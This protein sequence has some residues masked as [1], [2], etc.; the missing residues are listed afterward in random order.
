MNH[1]DTVPSPDDAQEPVPPIAED[2]TEHGWVQPEATV[3][4]LDNL[5]RADDDDD[6]AG[7]APVSKSEASSGPPPMPLGV[8]IGGGILILLLL[9]G[10]SWLG[11]N[12]GGS[13]EPTPTPTPTE[14]IRDWPLDPPLVHEDWVRG[15]TA[16]T[17]PV[18]GMERTVVA[19]TYS[20]G[21]ERFALVLSRPEL[22][23]PEYLEDAAIGSIEEVGESTCGLSQ[24]TDVPVCIQIVDQTGILLAGT[25]GQSFGE[26][27]ELLEEF[28]VLL[29]GEPKPTPAPE[30]EE[31][32]TPED[33]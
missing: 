33:E 23:M 12:L 24:D 19:S 2:P 9:G 26:L 18:D 14:T 27:D 1:P 16:T 4:S 13:P 7:W 10:A 11:L 29:A 8:K 30:P 21:S 15:E 22:D 31:S 17:E 20:T 5:T 28:Y 6:T 25:D 32:A 3:G